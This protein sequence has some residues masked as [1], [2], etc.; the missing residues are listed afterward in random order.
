MPFAGAGGSFFREWDHLSDDVEVLPVSLPGRERRIDQAPYRNVQRAVNGLLPDL[1]AEVDRDRPVAVFGHSLG[2]VLAFEIVRRLVDYTDL[3]VSRL[4]V[5]GSPGPTTRREVRATGLP[6]DEFLRQVGRF[7]GFTDE[8]MTFDGVRDM[9]LPTLRAD[10][11]MHENYRPSSRDPLPVP[12]TSL[13]GRSDELV[14]TGQAREWE[15]ETT[16][17]FTLVEPEGGHMY[18]VDRPEDVVRAVGS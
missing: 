6:D 15:R 1:L 2:A 5:S 10:V 8:A 16:A 3:P 4:L 13:R 12:I 18:L 9:V 7:A 11:E 17:G 14:D